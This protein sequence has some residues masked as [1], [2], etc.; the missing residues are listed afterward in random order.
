MFSR[1]ASFDA[2][3]IMKNFI[4][5]QS[6]KERP[7]KQRIGTSYAPALTIR[8][9]TGPVSNESVSVYEMVMALAKEKP[10]GEHQIRAVA[11]RVSTH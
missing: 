2:S 7:P 4:A 6:L 5:K 9:Y 1:M 3:A 11:E 10:T 8:R